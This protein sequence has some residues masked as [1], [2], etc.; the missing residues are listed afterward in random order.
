MIVQVISTN[1]NFTLTILYKGIRILFYF[2]NFYMFLDIDMSWLFKV[3]F[4]NIYK[5]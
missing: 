1:L 4:E 2:Y 5:G 3:G